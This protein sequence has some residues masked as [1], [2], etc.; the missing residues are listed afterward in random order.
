MKAIATTRRTVKVRDI[1]ASW[2]VVLPDDPEAPVTVWI[3]PAEMPSE[4]PLVDFIGSGKGVH[5][6]RA[7]ADTYIRRL[8]EEWQE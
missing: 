7:A 3:S 6:T 4:R 8:R 5:K 2:G 1:P